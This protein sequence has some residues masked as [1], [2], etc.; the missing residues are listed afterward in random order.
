MN[1][2]EYSI[3]IA[4]QKIRMEKGYLTRSERDKLKHMIANPK[5]YIK[6]ELQV[7]KGK[8]IITNRQLLEKPCELIT[9]ED[10][11]KEIIQDLKD[12]LNTFSNKAVGLSANQIGINKRISYIKIPKAVNK[13]IQYTEYVIINAKI[14]EKERIIQVKNESC[15]SFPGIPVT[16]KRYVFITVEYYNE[17][18][19]PQT[20][21][22]QDFEA[23][24]IQHECDH[25]SGITI[26]QRKWVGR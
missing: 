23:L 12:T 3:Y 22:L 18:M 15:L 11:I 17:K 10:N 1:K 4:E 9:K 21:I 5:I 7:N 16:T 14:L 26:F 19:E 2:L 20:R 13:E 8:S 25:Q 6:D 24:V